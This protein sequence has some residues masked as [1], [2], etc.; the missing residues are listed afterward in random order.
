M[1]FT[2]LADTLRRAIEI[3]PIRGAKFVPQYVL[4]TFPIDILT[5]KTV[6]I[7]VKEIG[8]PKNKLLKVF[9]SKVK[10]DFLVGLHRFK[11]VN[12]SDFSIEM[13][14][15]EVMNNKSTKYRLR[16]KSIPYGISHIRI[17][18]EN[19]DYLIEERNE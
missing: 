8:F 10:V 5:E 9:P 12:A 18:P 16:L 7:P 14:Y 1:S 2:N 11:Y 4:Y 15:E 6:E 3:Q 17:I 13:P 19:I